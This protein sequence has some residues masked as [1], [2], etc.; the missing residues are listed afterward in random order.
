MAL[1]IEIDHIQDASKRE[2]LLNTLKLMD[3]KFHLIEK[4]QSLEEYNRDLEEGDM[5]IENGQFFS[6]NDLKED[7]KKW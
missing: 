7:A 5:E 2:W 6:G 3:I 4:P 1:V